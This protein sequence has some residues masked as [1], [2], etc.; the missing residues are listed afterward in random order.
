MKNIEIKQILLNIAVCA[1][2]CDGH[3]DEREIEALKIIEKKSPYFSALD[4]SDTLE[5]SLEQSIKNLKDFQE[6]VF[7][8]IDDADLNIVQELIAME[9]SLRIIAAD[10]KEEQAEI[11]FINALRKHLKVSD[12]IIEERFGEIDYLE[13][14][15]PSE[16][17]KK[18]GLNLIGT[19]EIKTV[20]KK[21][22]KKK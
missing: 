5:K 8:N 7:K 12:D 1:I 3:I 6:N 15:L 11:E 21:K 17:E 9:I 16:F 18:E 4:L 22:K 20:E 13:S 14:T 10:E 2:S 19:T